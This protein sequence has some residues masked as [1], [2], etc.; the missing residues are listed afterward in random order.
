VRVVVVARSG[1]L[2]GVGVVVAGGAKMRCEYERMRRRGWGDV[3]LADKTSVATP[4]RASTQLLGA[5]LLPRER[6]PHI[7]PIRP[8]LSGLSRRRQP[9]DIRQHIRTVR[10]TT[11]TRRA[12]GRRRVSRAQEDGGGSGVGGAGAEGMVDEVGGVRVLGRGETLGLLEGDG[13]GH[14]G[15]GGSGGHVAGAGRQVDAVTVG[16]RSQCRVEVK[17]GVW[18]RECE[19]R[20]RWSAGGQRY[21]YGYGWQANRRWERDRERKQ[22]SADVTTRGGREQVYR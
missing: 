10:V 22:A 9:I 18:W 16:V 14:G 3:L 19:A 13:A 20:M 11:V 2:V 21:R 7:T 12:S 4:P 5:V 8:L 1:A 6:I 15:A 17:C